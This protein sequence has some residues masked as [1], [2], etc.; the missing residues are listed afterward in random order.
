MRIF[1]IVFERLGHQMRHDKRV[2]NMTS[3]THRD[4]II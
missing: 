2:V 3:E 4:Y 1:F